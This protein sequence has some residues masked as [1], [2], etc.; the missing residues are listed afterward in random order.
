MVSL[1]VVAEVCLDVFV[2]GHQGEE[3]TEDFIVDI[4][5][6]IFFR[7]TKELE[8]AFAKTFHCTFDC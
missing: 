1:M 5:D 2:F 6:L 7:I 4:V 3:L 8:N